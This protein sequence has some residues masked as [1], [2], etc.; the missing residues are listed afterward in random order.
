MAG[1]IKQMIQIGVRAH[2]YGKNTPDALFG[3]IA[4]DGFTCMQLALKKAIAGVENL[5][6]VTPELLDGIDA[7]RGRAGLTVAVLGAYVSLSLTDTNL[8]AQNVAEFIGNIPFA[9]RLGAVC[10]GTETTPMEQQPGVARKE[11][12]RCLMD[13]LD[14]IMPVGEEYGVTVAIEPV[15]THALNTPEL[16]A[17]MLKTIRSP[18][19][20]II[21]DPVNLF[22][23]EALHDQR[24][25]WDRCFSCFGSEIVAVHL[26]GIRQD[27]TGG[28]VSC[29]Y[30]KS[31]IDYPYIFDG[32]KK[33]PQNFNILREEV[34]PVHAKQDL[35]FIRS[36]LR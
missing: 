13:S 11:A 33:L 6:D 27:E 26:K 10:I 21:F 15:Y 20:K 30:P 12:L 32:L 5:G 3:R 29:E 22:S 14:R 36:L 25:L 35:A 24:S 7:A 9:K 19:L 18:K 31:V 16:T 4:A 23:E 1:E 28:L 2:D 34:R 17:E 8:R